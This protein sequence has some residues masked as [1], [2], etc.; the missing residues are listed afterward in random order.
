MRPSCPVEPTRSWSPRPSTT[1]P[2]RPTRRS[3]P[4]GR[5]DRQVF[6]D[7][8]RVTKTIQNYTD[9]DPATGNSDE[10]VT[11]EMTY[12]A[13]GNLATLT[14]KNPTTGDQ[15]TTYVYGT[16]LTDSEIATSTLKRAEIY[17][18]SD[19]TTALGDGADSTYDRIEFKYDRQQ[20]VIEVK[21]QQETVHTFDFD[22]LG[23]QT[24][25]RV[26]SL[27][28]GVDGAVRRIA[29]EY[30]VLGRKSR[31][32]SYDNPTVGSGSIVNDLAFVYD[33]F[34]QL[35]TEY[36]EHGGAVNT[37]TS[38]KGQYAY[39][40]GSSNTIRLTKMT[41]PRRARVELQLW[42]DWLD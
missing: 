42:F 20:R 11:V 24:Q 6:D 4:A 25:D 31:I 17:P 10:D 7:A 14:A 27:G 29:T 1:T 13:D 38:L 12:N 9:G 3:T 41:Y 40:D 8:G 5:E 35:V 22:A 15:T 32:T 37:G 39:A 23:R 21:D 18:D 34:G 33:D 30:D 19:D 36:Q 26:T 2:A 28:S 16:T